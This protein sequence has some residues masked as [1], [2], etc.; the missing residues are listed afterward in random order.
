MLWFC[1]KYGASSSSS[2]RTNRAASTKQPLVSLLFF[3]IGFLLISGIR[4]QE[5]LTGWEYNLRERGFTVVKGVI[6]YERAT[7]YQQKAYDWLKSFGTELNFDR[8][9]TW[10]KENLPVQSKA[11]TFYGYGVNHEK[12]MWDARQEPGVLDAFATIWGSN[13]LLVSFDS[14]NITFPNRKDVPRLGPWEH[15]DQSPF[16]KGLLCVHGIIVLSPSGPEDGG[17]VVYPGAHNLM[18]EFFNTQ[19][20]KSTWERLDKWNF[21][22]AQL[23]WFAARGIQPHKVCAEVGDLILWDG[24]TIHYGSEPTEKSSQIRTATY[25][26]YTPARLATEETLKKKAEILAQ[27]GG[28]THLPHDRIRT[29]DVKTYLEDGT[30]DP[31]DRDEPIEKPEM[32]DKLLKLAGVK[33]Y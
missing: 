9:E 12:F 33:K 15:I 26:A 25:V 16:R 4:T 22:D 24:R 28:T 20:D 7:Q 21:N 30:R 23:S 27:W 3:E 31:R 17:L 5:R 10:I 13:E 18:D 2:R 8:P 11:N 32:T 19:T 29:R 1:Y 6:S 14:L